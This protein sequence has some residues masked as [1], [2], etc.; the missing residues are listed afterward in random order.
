MRI[1]TQ[2]RGAKIGEEGGVVA[3]VLLRDGLIVNTRE[4]ALSRGVA[5]VAITSGLTTTP[6][7]VLCNT[8]LYQKSCFTTPFLY[9]N[10]QF[11]VGGT[12]I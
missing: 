5:H 11:I 12:L 9:F 4:V 7:R 1:A 8:V 3:L 6:L 2:S 10:M